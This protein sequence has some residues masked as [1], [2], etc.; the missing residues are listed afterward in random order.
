MYPINNLLLGMV[1]LLEWQGLGKT[2]Q[3]KHSGQV[4]L[5]FTLI[6]IPLKT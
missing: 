5:S 1:F 6:F 2:N 4:R 3:A